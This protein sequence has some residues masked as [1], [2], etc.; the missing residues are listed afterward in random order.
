MYTNCRANSLLEWKVIVDQDAERYLL[1]SFSEK[2]NRQNTEPHR[3]ER[4]QDRKNNQE[5]HHTTNFTRYV[6]IETNPGEKENMKL[7][8]ETKHTCQAAKSHKKPKATTKNPNRGNK[9]K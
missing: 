3:Q 1:Q 6:E 4:D 9:G 2:E 8:K 5:R 7:E